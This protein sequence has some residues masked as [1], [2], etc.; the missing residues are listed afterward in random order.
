M[1]QR[2]KDLFPRRPL[3]E[4]AFAEIFEEYYFLRD[5]EI[6]EKEALIIIAKEQTKPVAQD[7]LASLIEAPSFM[8]GLRAFP[9]F[10]PDYMIALLEQGQKNN[11][12][13]AA[14]KSLSEHL[15]EL[16]LL[17]R[18]GQSYKQQLK[19]NSIYPLGTLV[20]CFFVIVILSVFVVPVFD[21]VYQ[22]FGA[23]LPSLTLLVIT[24]SSVFQQWWWIGVLITLL[25]FMG[26]KHPK[27]KPLCSKVSL[28]FPLVKSIEAA[29]TLQTLQILL[30]HN[31]ALAQA[32]RLSATAS[33]NT[34]VMDSLM[35]SATAVEQKKSFVDCL[36]QQHVFPNRIFPA[37]SV[38]EKTQRLHLLQ[39]SVAKNN[40]LLE[41][42][43]VQLTQVTHQWTLLVVG[44]L[45]GIVVVAMY[46]PIFQMGVAVG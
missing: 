20:F 46:L 23:E 7:F 30:S 35:Q 37:L 36:K 6:P 5:A 31:I 12:E 1:K 19:I 32:L 15:R 3:T 22:S 11:E 2:P 16:L 28:F 27:S 10:A 41:R 29:Q 42:M 45:V 40:A 9:Q 26:L 43:L 25:A 38:F 24:V 14:L 18:H 17:D 33:Q 34:V 44:L 13:I 8:V 21:H 4:E 39:K